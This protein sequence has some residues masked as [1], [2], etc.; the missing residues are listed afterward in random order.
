M[1]TSGKGSFRLWLENLEISDM[2]LNQYK[3]DYVGQ[4]LAELKS[5][6]PKEIDDGDGWD[7]F[8]GPKRAKDC[9]P[10]DDIA[11]AHNEA[12]KAVDKALFGSDE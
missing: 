3:K 8:F 5:R 4:I 11:Y 2:R 1:S 7:I 10:G 9:C 6:L 12:L